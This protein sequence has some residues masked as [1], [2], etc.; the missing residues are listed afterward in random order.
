MDN[1]VFN[2]QEDNVTGLNRPAGPFEYSLAL[3]FPILATKQITGVNGEK[4]K[5]DENGQ[6]LFKGNLTEDDNGLE[7]YD[8][9]STDRIVTAWEE[10]KQEYNLVNEDGSTTTI[11]N[12]TQVATEWDDLQPVMVPNVVYRSVSF[13]EQPSLFSFEELNKVKQAS[14][15]KAYK[16]QLLV[17]YDEDFDLANF[18]SELSDH[19]ANMGDG[20]LALH[21][22]GKCRT[23]KLPLGQ[24]IEQVRLYLEAQDGII[25]EVGATV[26][27]YITVIDG[28][29]QLPEP[30]EELYIR[31]TNTTESYKEVYAFGLLA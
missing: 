17:Y 29:A 15:E 20:V 23:R 2:R 6:P 1:V 5:T 9:V 25:V 24:S 28:I 16:G 19:A 18:S 26:A 8:E 3:P 31:F 12:T 4:Q 22:G 30:A 14:L 10:K 21:P 7:T 11:S 27:S 13:A